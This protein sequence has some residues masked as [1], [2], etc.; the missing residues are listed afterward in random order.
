MRPGADVTAIPSTSSSET[1][2]SSSARDTTGTMLVRCSREAISGTTPPNT[3]CMSCD[4]ITSDF[5]ATA[6][7]LPWRTDADVSS[8]DVSIP[9]IVG[10]LFRLLRQQLLD[11]RPVLGRVPVVRAEEL[12]ADRAVADDD[13]GLR[14]AHRLIVRAH[15]ALCAL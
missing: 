10:M 3:R 1:D 14:I 9:R 7:A 5:R 15:V 8:H 11:Q 13:D 2:A 6:S 12:S 4:R